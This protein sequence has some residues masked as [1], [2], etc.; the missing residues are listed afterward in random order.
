MSDRTEQK[1]VTQFR[2]GQGSGPIL[3]GPFNDPHDDYSFPLELK[4]AG[5]LKDE[6]AQVGVRFRSFQ[7]INRLDEHLLSLARW[8][9]EGRLND[10]FARTTESPSA[11]FEATDL[12]VEEFFREVDPQK[13][14]QNRDRWLEVP[15]PHK[16]V[17]F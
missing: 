6:K 3:H 10:H 5:P 13:V 7:V 17:G 14:D 1:R 9:A 8:I 12:E 2:L 15:P 16:K 11:V 4:R